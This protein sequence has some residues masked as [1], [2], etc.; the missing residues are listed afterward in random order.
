M[1]TKEEYE[2]FVMGYMVEMQSGALTIDGVCELIS[3]E[4]ASCKAE[5]M[6]VIHY[7]EGRF[8]K[9]REEAIGHLTD[10]IVYGIN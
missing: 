3:E 9:T 5:T 4:V 8:K 6:E 1:K 2:M 7:L 10:D